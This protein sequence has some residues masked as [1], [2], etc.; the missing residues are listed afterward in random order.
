VWLPLLFFLA[1]CATSRPAKAPVGSAPDPTA[2]HAPDPNAPNPNA[3]ATG[4]LPGQR[5]RSAMQGALVGAMI[6]GQAGPIGA[7]VGAATFLIYGAVTG[8]LPLGG[9]GGGGG[10][11]Y[12]SGPDPGGAEAQREA[13]VEKEIDRQASLESDIQDELKRQETLLKQIDQ[14]DGTKG[15]TKSGAAKSGS[16]AATRPGQPGAATPSAEDIAEKADPRVAPH[17]P[18]ARDLPESI[19]DE[20]RVTIAAGQWGPDTKKQTVI[21]R[22]LDADR[23]G[24]PEEVRYFDEKSG[25]LLRIEDDRD[26]DGRIDSWTTYT[27]GAVTERDLDENHDGKPDVWEHYQNGVM[28]AREV[29]RD[30]NGAKDAFYTYQGGSL[31]EERHDQNGDGK[32]DRIV[33]YQDRRLVSVEEDRNHD[34]KMDTWSTYGTGPKGEEVVVRVEKDTKG[35]GKPDTFE[36]YAQEDGKTV[37]VKREEDVNGDGKIDITSLYEK[38]K[39]VKR[40]IADPAL[41]PL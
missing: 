26:Y 6:G 21:A 4:P 11:A 31:V 18:K 41:T 30:G 1:A 14:Q 27:N 29:D 24:H 2:A 19:F 25:Q 20:K 33:H 39:L 9:G 34:G 8:N 37:L 13:Q 7:A 22:S 36:T 32:I 28:T 35:T 40:E 23:D 10:G 12:P 15:T 17:A 5:A 16:N 38:G 3:V